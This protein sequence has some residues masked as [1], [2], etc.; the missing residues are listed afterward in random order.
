MLLIYVIW[1]HDHVD[2]YTLSHPRASQKLLEVFV[3]LCASIDRKITKLYENPEKPSNPT[4]TNRHSSV[5]PPLSKINYSQF[6]EIWS[7]EAI[8][9]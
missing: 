2:I 1:P 3:R 9:F 8:G 5:S 4:E 6:H 7:I